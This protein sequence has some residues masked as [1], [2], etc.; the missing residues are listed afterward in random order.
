[1]PSSLSWIDQDDDIRSAVLE[2]VNMPGVLDELGLG[3]IRDSISDTLFPGMST[4]HTRLRYVYFVKWAYQGLEKAASK[5]SEFDFTSELKKAETQLADKMKGKTDEKGIVGSRKE[6][7]DVKVPPSSIYWT[8]L[9]TWNILQFKSNQSIFHKMLS[10]RWNQRPKDKEA[11]FFQPEEIWNRS[12]PDPPNGFPDSLM[13]PPFFRLTSEEADA[14]R[15]C[16]GEACPG[17]LLALLLEK[18][19]QYGDQYENANYPW[20]L[21][22]IE[23]VLD[24]NTD[25]ELRGLL[26]HAQRYSLAVRGAIRLYNL[27][28]AKEYYRKNATDHEKSAAKEEMIHAYQEWYESW[29]SS[30]KTEILDWDLSDFF[31]GSYGNCSGHNIE[32]NGAKKFLIRWV[33]ILQDAETSPI[34]NPE[35]DELVEK[36]EKT[37]KQGKSRFEND[38]WTPSLPKK[39]ESETGQENDMMYNFRWTRVKSHLKD[40]Y[41]ALNTTTGENHA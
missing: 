9:G 38:Q 5:R 7:A 21:L 12:L 26:K 25:K 4:L 1:M 19:E 14:L 37:S 35:A 16:I 34:D 28:L 24:D 20:D 32:K 6:N 23:G 22:K 18:L 10:S 29:W 41:E 15:V 40:L 31:S 39:S 30:S 27:L 11:D 13:E 17:T 8:A 2:L 36:R 3:T 33:K